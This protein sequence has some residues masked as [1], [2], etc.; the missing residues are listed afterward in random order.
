MASTGDTY[1]AVAEEKLAEGQKVFDLLRNRPPLVFQKVTEAIS[2]IPADQDET[3]RKNFNFGLLRRDLEE[4]LALVQGSADVSVILSTTAFASAHMYQ[5]LSGLADIIEAQVGIEAIKES[6]KK[7]DERT[8]LSKALNTALARGDWKEHDRIVR[9]YQQQLSAAA[10][11][12]IA[13]G[14]EPTPGGGL[15]GGGTGTST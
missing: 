6:R 5:A 1:R 12:I 4:M 7:R 14:T 11:A 15:D 2:R 9:E 8:A 3:G 13:G 10:D